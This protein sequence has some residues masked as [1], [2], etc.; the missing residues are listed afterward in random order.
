MV[1][2]M[3]DEEGICPRRRLNPARQPYLRAIITWDKEPAMIRR[4]D[5]RPPESFAHSLVKYPSCIAY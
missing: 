2:A 5:N 3:M 4:R 1:S